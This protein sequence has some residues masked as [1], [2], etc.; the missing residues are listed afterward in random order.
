MDSKAFSS[1]TWSSMQ[2]CLPGDKGMAMVMAD[3]S[4]LGRKRPGGWEHKSRVE[5]A[6]V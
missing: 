6:P 3:G 2:V 1:L 4:D 5:S